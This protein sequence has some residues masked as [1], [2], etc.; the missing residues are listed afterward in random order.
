MGVA[1]ERDSFSQEKLSHCT[2]PWSGEAQRR[3]LF[4]KYVPYGMH[5]V[6]RTYL[7]DDPGLTDAQRARLE[8]SDESAT[9]DPLPPRNHGIWGCG[10]K[11]DAVGAVVGG[12]TSRIRDRPS[13]RRTAKPSSRRYSNCRG[14][15]R[16]RAA[17]SCFIR[18][19]VNQHY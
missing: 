14:H 5:H 16:D 10:G 3:T 18:S 9:N 11:A 12:S 19:S 6:D 1:P 13:R 7:T 15:G 8:F 17:Q 2:I 4:F